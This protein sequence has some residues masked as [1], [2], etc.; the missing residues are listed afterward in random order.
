LGRV[1]D[2]NLRDFIHKLEH[3]TNLFHE[4]DIVKRA[5]PEHLVYG[6]V[7]KQYC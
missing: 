3:L 1:G 5:S 4:I 6:E 2:Q 7:S